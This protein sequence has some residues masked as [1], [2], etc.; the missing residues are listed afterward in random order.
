MKNIIHISLVIGLL[1]ICSCS[2]FDARHSSPE[3]IVL[4]SGKE[5]QVIEEPPKLSN[6]RS[7]L[8]FQAEQS[9]QP[10]AAKP[11][12]LEKNRTINTPP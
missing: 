12:P 7:R 5:W 11:A 10:E 2:L 3:P 6:D 8:P 9:V 4:H 1:L